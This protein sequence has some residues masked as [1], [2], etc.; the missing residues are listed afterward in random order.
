MLRYTIGRVIWAAISILVIISVNFFV[1]RLLPGDPITAL[2][3]DFPT[4]PGYVEQVRARLGLD[5]PLHIQYVRYLAA[6]SHGDFGYSFAGMQP[7]ASLLLDKARFTLLL[8]LPS[9]VAASLIGVVCALWV[10]PRPGGVGDGVVTS[11]SLLFYSVPVFW[12]GQ[13]LILVFAIQLGWLPAQG[14]VS[15]RGGMTGGLGRVMDVLAHMALPSLCIVLSYSA[16]VLRVA[17][18]SVIGVLRDEFV[19]TARAKG[20]SRRAVLFGHVLPNASVP[21]I[22]I[23]AFNFGYSLTGSIFTETVFSWPGLGSA[24]LSSI[25]SRDYPVLQGLFLLASST[26]VVANI[27]ADLACAFIDP[28]VRL[29][30]T[31]AAR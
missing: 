22:T 7:V 2:V 12:F 1:T 30:V 21:I 20:L 25:N 15:L 14:M 26:V 18:A 16:I 5:L 27:L 19:I 4:P 6:I 11:L 9:L 3:G 17:R 23:I 24:F 29:S 10:A 8:M 28:R 31:G 13:V